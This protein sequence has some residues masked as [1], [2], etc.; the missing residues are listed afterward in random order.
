LSNETISVIEIDSRN[1]YPDR[2]L[3]GVA[4]ELLDL[5]SL[6]IRISLTS[7]RLRLTQRLERVTRGSEH[8]ISRNLRASSCRIVDRMLPVGSP[9]LPHGMEWFLGCH[10]NS[11]SMP[12]SLMT[13]LTWGTSSLSPAVARS[14]QKWGSSKIMLNEECISSLN[15]FCIEVVR[16][17]LADFLR[18][19][20]PLHMCAT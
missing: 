11:T 8:N 7:S 14:R 20:P 1:S 15:R 2:K 17:F 19:V 5:T 9:D 12:D 3:H 13:A 6:L 16:G 18:D 4:A 10:Y